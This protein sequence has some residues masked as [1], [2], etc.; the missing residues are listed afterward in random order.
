M[1]F[2]HLV[3]YLPQDIAVHTWYSVLVKVR[4]ICYEFNVD[5]PQFT[6][7]VVEINGSY[8]LLLIIDIL[9]L[10]ISIRLF[11]INCSVTEGLTV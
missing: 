10:F 7:S 3:Q 9:L 5:P 6:Y 4:L 1:L 2:Y 8:I 11:V